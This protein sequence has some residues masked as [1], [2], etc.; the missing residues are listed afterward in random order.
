PVAIGERF[1]EFEVAVHDDR[2]LEPELFNAAL[3]VRF[4]MREEKLGRV[5]ADD[6]QALVAITRVPLF[7]I[8]QRADAVDAGVVPEVDQ[9]GA[10]AQLAHAQ[11]R[12]V[13]PYPPNLGGANCTFFDLH[14]AFNAS[15]LYG[16]LA[17]LEISERDRNDSPQARGSA[18]NLRM[19]CSR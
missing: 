12:R 18:K 4:V 11:R 1:P 15:G 13:E 8:R 19:H 5:H 7:Y 9:D 17:S 3:H 16:S 6:S 10:S 14:V 2:I